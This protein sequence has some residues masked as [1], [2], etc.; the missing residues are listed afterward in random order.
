MTLVILFSLKNNGVA[1]EWVLQPIF[2][3][4]YCYQLEQ[5]RKSHGNVDADA[6]YKLAL[7][8]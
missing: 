6:W 5:N 1:P 3:R 4:L 7:N 2:K 8:I